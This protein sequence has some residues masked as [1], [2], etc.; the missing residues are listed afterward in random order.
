MSIISLRSPGA[1]L[2]DICRNRNG[3]TPDLGN[4]PKKLLAR[5][6]HRMFVHGYNEL[7]SKFERFQ[8]PMIAHLFPLTCLSKKLMPKPQAPSLKTISASR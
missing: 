2:N 3:R 7:V 5:K 4:K 1:T 8:F 6:P